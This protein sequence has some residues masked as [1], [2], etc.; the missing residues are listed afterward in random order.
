MFVN[1]AE[2]NIRY[3][4]CK[5]CNEFENLLKLCKKCGCFMPA[6]CKLNISTCP[7]NLWSSSILDTTP[8]ESNNK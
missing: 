3:N 7:N 4:I 8:V 2:Y 5:S 6:K 1:E